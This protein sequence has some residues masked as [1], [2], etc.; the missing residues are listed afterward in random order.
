MRRR[1]IEMNVGW[2]ETLKWSGMGTCS[3]AACG[4][5]NAYIIEGKKLASQTESLSRVKVSYVSSAGQRIGLVDFWF[6]G[7]WF[8]FLLW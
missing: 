5:C 2:P 7:P 3:S 4:F 6:Q 1:K 8:N